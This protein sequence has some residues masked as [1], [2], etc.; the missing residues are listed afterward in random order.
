MR[1]TTVIK[2]NGFAIQSMEILR[3]LWCLLRLGEIELS[4]RFM[5]FFNGPG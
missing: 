1:T 4:Q 2:K 5:M 3:T